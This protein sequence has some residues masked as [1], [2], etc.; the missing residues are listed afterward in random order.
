[1]EKVLEKFIFEE[2]EPYLSNHGGG[3]EILNFDNGANLTLRL[4]GKCCTC[5]QMIETN[6]NFI[7]KNI[8]EKFPEIKNIRIECGVSQELW[9]IAKKILR[10]R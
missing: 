7:K 9:D 1:M 3:I 5:P 10:R 4:K 8:Y 2:I 6:E